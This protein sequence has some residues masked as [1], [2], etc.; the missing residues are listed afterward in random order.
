MIRQVDSSLLDEWERL[1][2][3]QFQRTAAPATPATPPSGS[4]PDVTKDIRGFVAAIRNRLFTVLRALA[5]AEFESALAQLATITR[6]DGTSWTVEALRTAFEGYLSEHER[7]CLDPN[8]RNMRHTYILK[9]DPVS[10]WRVQQMLVDPAGLND[11]V[12]E[13]RVNLD[14]ARKTGEPALALLRLG[15]LEEAQEPSLPD[16]T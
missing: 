1:R 4:P 7:L 3:P 11:W 15:P 9:D 13:F 14:T 12:A 2:D 6:P 16:H 10:S 8:A 5:N